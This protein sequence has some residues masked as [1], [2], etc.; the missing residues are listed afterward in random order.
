MVGAGAEVAAEEGGGPGG[1]VSWG[2]RLRHGGAG[3]SVAI[4][5]HCGCLSEV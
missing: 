5:L 4:V 3:F 2:A 1:E